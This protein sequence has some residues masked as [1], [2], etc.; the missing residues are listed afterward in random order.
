MVAQQMQA[1]QPENT[2]DHTAFTSQVEKKE[3]VE[4]KKRLAHVAAAL[5][6]V[7][8]VINSSKDSALLKVTPEGKTSPKVPSTKPLPLIPPLSP[9]IK[10]D[11]EAY[12]E[13]MEL[14]HQDWAKL[15]AMAKQL[16]HMKN[17]MY[18]IVEIMN[19]FQNVEGAKVSAFSSLD[20]VDSDIRSQITG[21]E[22]EV[23]AIAG[24][25]GTGHDGLTPTTKQDLEALKLVLYVKQ[26]QA[27]MDREGGGSKVI[28][29]ATLKNLQEAIDNI[30]TQFGKAWGHPQEMAAQINKWVY[31]TSH[32]SGTGPNQKLIP[33]H[34]S[35]QLRNIQFG[36][37]QANQTVSAMSTSTNTQLEF[38]SNMFKQ[39]LGIDETAMQSYQK[40]NATMIQNQ[41]SN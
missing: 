20:N 11:L 13:A 40:G 5:L 7:E 31:Y 39:F 32:A 37:Q 29:K 34:F 17:T 41:R 1:I 21:A 15:K 26:I 3:G 28:G 27:F 24:G 33:A 12:I 25:K 2:I 14:L 35:P 6:Y 36:F 30:K 38:V 19:M 4:S 22:G 9:Q 10:K 16:G 18:G 23:N 8:R